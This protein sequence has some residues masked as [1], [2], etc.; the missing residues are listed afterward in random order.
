MAASDP[1]RVPLGEAAYRWLRAEIVSCR[2][3]PGQRVT[4]RGLAAR[5]GLGVS[6]IRDALTRLDH[7]GLVRTIPRK[8]YQ[9]KPLT[10]KSVDDLF[11]FWLAIGPELVR[12]GVKGATAA[13]R[14]RAADG[15]RELNRLVREDRPSRELA[16]RGVEIASRT[17]RVL[18]EATRNEH[19]IRTFTRVDGEISRVWTLVIDS[20]LMQPG[21]FSEDL[22]RWP[23]A[24]SRR[25]GDA[26][27]DFTRQYI[28][29]AHG[30]V[31]RTLARWPSV[32]TTEVVPLYPATRAHDDQA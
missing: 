23:E 30:R 1:E 29:Q 18:A 31:I 2:L 3:P 13:E 17:F 19:F 7:D 10:M 16:L 11:H 27:A 12:L 25:D 14:K 28:E 20:E 22:G 5:T 8:G 9:V 15:F 32:V 21:G 26:A 6:P 4:E 24:L